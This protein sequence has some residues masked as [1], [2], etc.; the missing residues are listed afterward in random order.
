[1]RLEWQQYL[2]G[3]AQRRAGQVAERWRAIDEH[4][5]PRRWQRSR[6]RI[7]PSARST[8]SVRSAVTSHDEAGT[9]S[10]PAARDGW[11]RS[12]RLCVPRNVSNSSRPSVGPGPIHDDADP[13]GSRSMTSVR[14]ADS[15]SAPARLTVVAVFPQPP[16]RLIIAMVRIGSSPARSAAPVSRKARA[17]RRPISILLPHPAE[18]SQTVP[19]GTTGMVAT[20]RPGPSEGGQPFLR[21]AFEDAPDDVLAGLRGEDLAAGPDR[22]LDLLVPPPRL[23]LADAL[24]GGLPPRFSAAGARQPFRRRPSPAPGGRS[25]AAAGRASSCRGRRPRSG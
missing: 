12:M 14:R 3:A 24:E 6:A 10:T 13:W 20:W 2:A 8:W 5:V 18:S 22:R 25:R 15:P 19:G 23:R 4:E 11:T 1:M 16:L 17:E 21:T 7:A 9:M